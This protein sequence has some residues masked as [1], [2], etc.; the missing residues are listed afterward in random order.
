MQLKKGNMASKTTFPLPGLRL[1][2]V[3]FVNLF[4]ERG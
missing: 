3:M 2:L 1:N 4:M